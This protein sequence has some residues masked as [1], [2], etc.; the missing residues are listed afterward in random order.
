MT[1]IH[2]NTNKAFIKVAVVFDVLF[3]VSDG[4]V[5]LMVYVLALH[6]FHY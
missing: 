6:Y 5:I 2:F 3:D 4:L 1:S